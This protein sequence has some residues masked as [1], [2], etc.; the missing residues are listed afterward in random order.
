M[1]TEFLYRNKKVVHLAFSASHY[2]DTL[3][4][5][6]T[7]PE[8]GDGYAVV[9]SNNSVTCLECKKMFRELAK[10]MGK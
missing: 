9:E 7:D 3:C 4:G 1:K 5:L 10:D 8:P 6:P 2:S